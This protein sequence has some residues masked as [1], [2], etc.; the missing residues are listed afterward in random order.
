MDCFGSCVTR[1]DNCEGGEL[2]GMMA[3]VENLCVPT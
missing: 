2:A 1:F 3:G